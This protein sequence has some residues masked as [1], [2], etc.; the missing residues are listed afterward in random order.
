MLRRDARARGTEL[1]LVENFF[2]E[3]KRLVPN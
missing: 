3:L 2:E 1:I